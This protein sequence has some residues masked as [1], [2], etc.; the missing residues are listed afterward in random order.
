MEDVFDFEITEDGPA[1][2]Q[3]MEMLRERIRRGKLP[4]G[5]RFPPIGKLAKKWNTNYFTVQNALVPLTNE[6]LI[7][8]SPRNGTFVRGSKII[9]NS[10][11]LYFGTQFWRSF[12][13][14]FYSTL[15]GILS[16]RL[17]ELGIKSHLWIDH[18]PAAEQ[19]TPWAPLLKAVDRREVQGVIATMV[20]GHDVAWLE[21][22]AVPLALA[23]GWGEGNPATVSND[24]GQMIAA[25]IRRLREQNCKTVGLIA[26]ERK[27]AD[28]FR[29][30]AKKAGVATSEEWIR[31]PL[32]AGASEAAGSLLFTELWSQKK[33]P[34]GLLVFPDVMARGVM[35][36]MLE[37]QV[38][39]PRDLKAIF[40]T[41]AEMAFYCPL[42][43]EWIVTH[44]TRLADTLITSIQRQVAGE[45]PKPVLIPLE[46]MSSAELFRPDRTAAKKL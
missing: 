25:S 18:R 46:L 39:L 32:K 5:T 8:S 2:R 24:L 26:N 31:L 41:N 22:L 23:W 15:F 16:E 6:G 3:I 10:V 33:R 17:D 20:T 30:E 44:A 4:V 40:H 12:S 42:S 27:L 19:S 37:K 7:E 28:L 9:C 38:R 13:D 1:Y 11:G 14:G 29:R 21:Q 43:V 36:A 45:G 35:V 34:D